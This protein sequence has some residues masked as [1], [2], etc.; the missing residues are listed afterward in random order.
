MYAALKKKLDP[1]LLKDVTEKYGKC[2]LYLTIDS[3]ITEDDKV[4]AKNDVWVHGEVG[5]LKFNFKNGKVFLTGRG[6]LAK[7]YQGLTISPYPT[8]TDKCEPWTPDNLDKVT[9]QIIVTRI[10]LVIADVDNG[11]LQEVK[12]SPLSISDKTVFTG[13]MKCKHKQDDGKIIDVVVPEKIPAKTGS[14][15][16]GYFTVAHMAELEYE[17]DVLS[18]D[19]NDP[20]VARYT[21]EQPSFSPGYGTWSEDSTFELVNKTPK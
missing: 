3:L 20:I 19:G 8:P 6:D 14:L 5:P 1:K 9:P 13:N 17:F 7:F 2:K 11:V 18:P 4:S 12:L 21:S 16:N 15:W 10:D